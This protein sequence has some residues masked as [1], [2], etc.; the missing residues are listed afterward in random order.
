MRVADICIFL[1]KRLRQVDYT[2]AEPVETGKQKS[3]K[4]FQLQINNRLKYKQVR[5]AV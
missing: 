2:E 5:T 4:K 1:F 3:R